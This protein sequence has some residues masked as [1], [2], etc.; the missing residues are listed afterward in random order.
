MNE[1]HKSKLSDFLSGPKAPTF[2]RNWVNSFLSMHNVRKP[3]YIEL[4]LLEYSTEKTISRWFSQSESTMQ[5]YTTEE[6]WNMDKLMVEVKDKYK[7]TCIFGSE[8][9]LQKF[10]FSFQHMTA[11]LCF[12]AIGEK[13]PLFCLINGLKRL[14][15]ELEESTNL[16]KVFFGISSSGWVS[17]SLFL[18]WAK[19]FIEWHR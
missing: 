2:N 15:P 4:D 12:N 10:P 18:G 19:L 14:H 5:Q 3:E 6:I 13:I 16:K 9:P 11:C 1:N 8:T 17:K 7:V